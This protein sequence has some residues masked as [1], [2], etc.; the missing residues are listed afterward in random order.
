MDRLVEETI[1]Y[2][3]VPPV[4]M[5]FPDITAGGGYAGTSGESSSFKHGF[6]NQTINHTEMLLA[7]GDVVRCSE[8]E[9]PDFFHGAAGAAVG[10]YLL[11]FRLA[12][13]PPMMTRGPT[14]CL[15]CIFRYSYRIRIVSY[16]I[17][18][19][20]IASQTPLHQ[21]CVLKPRC[22]SCDVAKGT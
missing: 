18:S 9:S 6:F 15:G 12:S 11:Y 10:T 2:G 1:R 7:N 17:A 16:R 20:R 8:N 13:A 22:T 19:H 14:R 4:V 21:D 5:E 3:L